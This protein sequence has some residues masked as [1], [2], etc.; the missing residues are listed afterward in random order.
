MNGARLS[1]AA[2]DSGSGAG[3][4]L[5]AF[6]QPRVAALLFLGFSSGLPLLLIFATLS[7]WLRE[8]GVERAAVTYFSW[9]ALGYSFKF[10]WAPLID[11]LPLPV[12]GPRLGQRRSWLLTAQVAVMASIAAMAMSDPGTPAGLTAMAFA[13]V[14]LGFSAATQDIVIDAYRIE[15]ADEKMQALLASAYVAGY[16]AGMLVAGAGALYLAAGFGTEADHYVYDA[17]K[18]TYLCMAGAML[19]GVVTTFAVGEPVRRDLASDF[20]GAGDY[21]RFFAVF[22]IMAAAFVALFVG[23]SDGAGAVHRWAAEGL[24]MPAAL[25]GFLA[26]A[27]RLTLALALALA[28]ARACVGVGIARAEMV[29]ETYVAPVLDFLRRYGRAAVPILLLVGFY[30]V[31]DI[32]LGAIA[33]V[34]YFDMGYSKEEIATVTKVFGLWMTILGGFLGAALALKYGVVRVLMLGAVLTVLTNLLFIALAAAPG[35]VLLLY[36]VIGADN[37]TAGIASAA[38]VAYLSSLTSLSFTAMQYAVL[39]SLMTLFPKLL[40]GYSG[41]VVD[42]FGYP[43]FFLGAAA[44]GVPVFLLIVW[45]ARLQGRREGE[46]AAAQAA[47]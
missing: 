41:Q 43:V 31:S 15:V 33:N 32:V 12:L 17:W 10:V 45:A 35:D 22:A 9:A 28:L 44:I 34:F 40:G 24:G 20:H 6:L 29:R 37:L 36:A 7:L 23:L 4:D 21:A 27:G 25:A 3:L 13:A 2:G 30:R 47:G 19:V 46:A 16:R 1:T 11:K 26:E 39:S 38:F 18:W 42:T 5:R 14:A 8:A